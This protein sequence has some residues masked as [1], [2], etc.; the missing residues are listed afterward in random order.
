MKSKDII[1]LMRPVSLGKP[2]VQEL[3]RQGV[4]IVSAD[5]QGPQ[6]DIVK[7]LQGVDVVISA[8]HYQS[9]QDEIPLAYAAKVAG[10]KRYVPCFFATVG[11]RGVM[12]LRDKVSFSF[13][14]TRTRLRSHLLKISRQKEDI[15]DHIQRI[16]LPYTVIDVGWWYQISLPRIPS[17][18]LDYAL[19]APANTVLGGGN[20]PSALTD[21]RDIG[22]YVAKIISDPQT[23][24]KKVFA[25]TETRTQ[26]QICELVERL[27][28]EKIEKAQ[29]WPRNFLIPKRFN[30]LLI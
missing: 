23:V 15:L 22:L 3:K 1:A 9:L 11:P 10:V 21:V 19:L 27:S 4:K 8:I 18:R 7:V 13:F 24:Q 17:G 25:F 16:R 26:N 30:Y 5:L 12:H 2:A 29:V 20:T 6:D 28:G 14:V